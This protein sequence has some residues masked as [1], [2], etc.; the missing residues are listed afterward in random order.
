[1]DYINKYQKRKSQVSRTSRNISVLIAW[2]L[3]TLVLF[4]FVSYFLFWDNKK[5]EVVELPKSS[6]ETQPKVSIPKFEP[7]VFQYRQ[8]LIHPEQVSNL[9]AYEKP[10][11]HPH[12]LRCGSFKRMSGAKSLITK[13]KPAADM[14]SLTSGK[15]FVV[16]SDWLNHKRAA[17][18]LVNNIKRAT[19]VASCTIQKQ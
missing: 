10:L 11:E 12:R 2:L 14:T 6:E 17:Q 18:N 13:I 16:V 5:E 15:W 8:R 7:G 4:C 1:M 9:P 3:A 19:G